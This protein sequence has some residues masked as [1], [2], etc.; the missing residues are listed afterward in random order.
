MAKPPAPPAWATVKSGALIEWDGTKWVKSS[1]SSTVPPAIGAVIGF[2][3]AKPVSAALDN[4]AQ[5]QGT[6]FPMP[7]KIGMYIGLPI[8]GYVIGRLL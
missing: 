4:L 7:G 5:S 6:D 1:C 2:V 8:L 3:A